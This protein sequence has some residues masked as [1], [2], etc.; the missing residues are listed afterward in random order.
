MNISMS[1]GKSSKPRVGVPWRTLSEET[2][3]K[4]PKIDA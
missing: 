3:N 1:S 4:R 2:Q